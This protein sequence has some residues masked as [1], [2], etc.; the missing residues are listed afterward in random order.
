MWKVNR[1]RTPSDGKSSLCLWQ[2]EL[3]NFIKIGCKI[4]SPYTKKNLFDT[5]GSLVFFCIYPINEQSPNF[6]KWSNDLYHLVWRDRHGPDHMVVGFT[7]TYAYH[8]WCCEFK[9]QS[10]QFSLGPLVSSTN[11]TVCHDITKILLKVVLN[12]IK[13]TTT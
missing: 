11:K 3:K 1:R 12:T 13:Q 8:H 4:T 2:G 6:R 10:G 9:S 5:F 7:T